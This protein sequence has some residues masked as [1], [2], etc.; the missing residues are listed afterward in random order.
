MFVNIDHISK[1]VEVME[2]Y[3]SDVCYNSKNVV[4]STPEM[5]IVI[6]G[7]MIPPQP[8]ARFT[9]VFDNTILQFPYLSYLLMLLKCPFTTSSVMFRT[10]SFRKNLTWKS[11]TLR[12]VCDGELYGDMLLKK[13]KVV[14]IP[15][16]GALWRISKYQQTGKVETN[17]A[18]MKL[19]GL[20]YDKI[21]STYPLWM[22]FGVYLISKLKPR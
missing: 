13:M 11:K 12:T 10:N 7:S 3:N 18:Y 4:G 14:S 9:H 1:Q 8:L 17:N 16:V 21:D 19:R 22:R 6:Q 5:G 15:M 2:K 20:L